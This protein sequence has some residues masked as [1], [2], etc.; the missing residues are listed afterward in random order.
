MS[1]KELT[2]RQKLAL[3]GHLSA[4]DWCEEGMGLL[5]AGMVTFDP[6]AA[7]S[8]PRAFELTEKGRAAAHALRN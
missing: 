5:S 7:P 6:L 4:A 3:A 8:D 2:D 1:L